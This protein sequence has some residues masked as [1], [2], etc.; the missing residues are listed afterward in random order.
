D[1]NGL[2]GGRVIVA[3]RADL[4]V[5]DGL[6]AQVVQGRDGRCGVLDA[7]DVEDG[8]VGGHRTGGV[9]RAGTHVRRVADAQRVV[10]L[11][12]PLRAVVRARVGRLPPGGRGGVG[13]M[14]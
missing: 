14:G 2:V 13:C 9:G 6:V 12:L 5:T 1:G 3:C 11:P 8:R 10:K 7:V 4:D